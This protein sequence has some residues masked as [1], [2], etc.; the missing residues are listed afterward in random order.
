M[1]I[2][3][4]EYYEK[5]RCIGGDCK[6]TCCAGWEVDVDEESFYYYQTVPGKFGERLRK[7]LREEREEKYFPLTKE[8]RCPFLN[9]R[10]L[11]DIY[12]E[13]GEEALCQVCT[14]YPRYFME[15]GNYQQ[16]DMSLSCME[17]GRIFFKTEGKIEYLRTRDEYEGEKLSAEEE[18]RLVE[19]LAVRNEAIRF[20]QDE[21]KES[22]EIT[23]S[24]NK[25]LSAGML[26]LHDK[27][28]ETEAEI[29]EN[30]EIEKESVIEEKRETATIF[31]DKFNAL[32]EKFPELSEEE[33]EG[34]LIELPKRFHKL[35][36]L[37]SRWTDFTE[38]LSE[39]LTER[40]EVRAD[41]NSAYLEKKEAER[42]KGNSEKEVLTELCKGFRSSFSAYDDA[43]RKLS[44]YFLFRYFIDAFYDN[45]IAD[46]LRLLIRALYSMELMGAVRLME[47]GSFCIGDMIDIAHL[48]S[49][50]VE[51]SEEN[52]N[53]FKA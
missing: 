35:E 44:V 33:R 41:G 30:E 24:T 53:L 39:I 20:M 51:H 26:S 27:K 46:I 5:F 37:D 12:T 29:E 50:E 11:C 48:F 9:Q 25:H 38:K 45:S 34:L 32:L 3:F 6:D 13:L 15:A 22:T 17:L 43:F 7:N 23:D 47:K 16:M 10:N 2:E 49:K 1:E 28:I 40:M 4:P 52:I 19:L 8:L 36:V 21:D 31:R 14:E 42:R 18:A